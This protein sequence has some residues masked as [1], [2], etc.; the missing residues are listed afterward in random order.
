ME[1]AYGA[2][3]YEQL[4][5][6]SNPDVYVSDVWK[7]LLH[8][9]GDKSV[10]NKDSNFFLSPK[11]YKNPKE[12]YLVV[13]KAITDENTTN[14]NHAI[15]RY[16]ARFNYILNTLNL[17]S[18]DFPQPVCA[19]YQE[20]QDKVLID[21]VAVV[22]AAE[23][24]QS[25]SSMMGHTFLKLSGHNSSGAKEHAFSYF[26]ALNKTNTLKF[27]I[28]VLTVGL[29]GIYLL[30]PYAEKTTE[31]LYGEKRSL[32][33]VKLNLSQQEKTNL[34]R[35]L[36]E[37][38]GKNIRYSIISH[39]CNTAVIS[40]LKTANADFKSDTLKPFVTPVEYLQELQK[41]QK[42]KNVIEM[43]PSV[44]TREKIKRYGV[45]NV[46]NANKASRLDVSFHNT[47][48]DYFQLKLS[49][50]YQDIK[51]INSAY[52]DEME[53][54]IGEITLG[55]SNKDKVFLQSVDI[56]KMRSVLDYSIQNDY[57]K[58]FKLTME[59]D[60]GKYNTSIK[61]TIEFGLGYAAYSKNV[62]FYVLPRLGWRYNHYSNFYATPEIGIITNINEKIK[63]INSYEYY[64]NTKRNNRGY[65]SKYNIYAGY[66]LYE[67]LDTYI[68][69]S[70]YTDANYRYETVFGIAYK[71]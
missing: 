54:K 61:P 66:K 12:E 25:P 70:Y 55:Y 47:K 4:L 7:N 53:S 27:Y 51:D 64:F 39:N 2:Y 30:S 16:P 60:L 63:I 37:L 5:N 45:K 21:E 67:N 33:E 42:T 15:C 57:S 22:F 59:N 24:N 38:K 10:I 43:N 52:F 40:I 65:N 71:F 44:Y 11:G 36:W 9:D 62:S 28:D 58:H 56:L 18:Q 29:D 32:W 20:Y 3:T 69:Y 19:S 14:D 23:N 50:V 34:K 1:N 8:Y 17:H 49:P 6:I 13:L 48:K 68:N 41:K 26:A 31:Y 46:L 35:H